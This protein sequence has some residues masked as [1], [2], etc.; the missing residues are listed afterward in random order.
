M[1]KIY[2][3][4]LFLSF[5]FG[6]NGSVIFYDGTAFEGEIVSVD[7]LYV[8]IIPTGL[9]LPE[10]IL[11]EYIATLILENG[12]VIV[13][14]SRA[15]Q[16][17]KD[18]KYIILDDYSFKDPWKS[19]QYFFE[20]G[21][22]DY[23][24]KSY[25][26]YRKETE[27]A[28]YQHDSEF[29]QPKYIYSS[30]QPYIGMETSGANTQKRGTLNTRI[31]LVKSS[32]YGSIAFFGGFPIFQSTSLSWITKDF[33]DGITLPNIGATG[34][35]PFKIGPIS[36]F[37]G[38]LMTM[39]FM[40]E[41]KE[42]YSIKA[43]QAAAFMNIGVSTLLTFLPPNMKMDAFIGSSYHIGWN[44]PY[45]G[46]GVILGGTLDYWFE[47]KPIGLRLFGN[48]HIIP[49]PGTTSDLPADDLGAFGNL[50]I[51]LLTSFALTSR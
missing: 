8:Y 2:I 1:R 30:P 35:I 6:V 38:H 14:N 9:P 28:G 12:F 41:F 33:D 45:T 32:T 25:G 34:T 46:I 50:G 29:N 18:E 15:V 23:Y 37:G 10:E 47:G 43:I 42:S 31:P 36:G 49:G 16:G 48:G 27:P 4:V 51:A 19:D 3:Y 39:G 11:T 7:P 20:S 40:S 21:L 22:D 26:D 17:Y 13:E 5:L 44:V 24:S